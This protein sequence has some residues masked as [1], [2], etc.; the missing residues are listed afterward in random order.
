MFRLGADVARI[1]RRLGIAVTLVMSLEV[2]LYLLW[3]RIDDNDPP[4]TLEQQLA[5]AAGVLLFVLPHLIAV[6]GFR[7]RPSLLRVA[8]FVGILLTCLSFLG[9]STIL[10]TIPFVLIPSVVYLVL[11]QRKP[12]ERPRVGALWLTLASILL[13]S[14]AGWSLFLTEDP[15]C[16]ILVRRAGQL[17]YEEP[18]TCDPTNSGVLGP[19][20]VEW[21]GTSDTIA[22]HEALLSV[23]LSGATLTMCLWGG[24]PRATVR[25]DS[26]GVAM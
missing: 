15:R 2:A 3:S 14:G 6:G 13:V 8:G 5:V 19:P 1:I 22:W 12:D 4:P 20:V 24:T 21:S 18:A 23:L 26:A 7:G 11:G 16:T 10:V 17:V 9:H 25:A